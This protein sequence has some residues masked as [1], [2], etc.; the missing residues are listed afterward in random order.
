MIVAASGLNPRITADI[1]PRDRARR[2]EVIVVSACDDQYSMPLNVMLHSAAVNLATESRLTV[3]FL[4]GGLSDESWVALRETLAG[5]PVDVLSIEPDYSL[6]DH[7]QTSHHVTPAA[8]LR[9]LTAELM[10]S[11]VSRAI[12]LDPDLLVRDDLTRLWNL[13][14]DDQYCL[15]APD[16]ACPW[17][18]AR[19]GCANWRRAIPWLASLKPVS[20][21]RELDLNGHAAYFNSGVMVLNLDRW[22][23]DQVAARMLDCLEENRRHVWCWDQYALNV[24]FHGQWGRLPARWNQGSHCL[25][26]PSIDDSPIEIAEFSEMVENPAII[27]FTTEFKPW[28]YHWRHLRG[29]AFF[30]ALDATSYRGWRPEMPPFNGYQWRQRVG[31]KAAKWVLPRYRKLSTIWTVAAS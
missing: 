5:L 8:Y 2:T 27:H 17:I 6:V 22:R 4:D 26:F 18:D 20:N 10:P 19:V 12:Y 21:Y 9:L 23:D 29:D 25:D 3:Y 16:V 15:A 31:V 13:P 30:A 7:L 1:A 24:V 11:H 14:V 28:H